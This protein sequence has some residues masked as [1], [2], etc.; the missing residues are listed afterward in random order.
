MG[1]ASRLHP[2]TCAVYPSA[3]PKVRG[4]LILECASDRRS[5]WARGLRRPLRPI[6][7]AALL[8]GESTM[9][10]DNL[11]AFPFHDRRIKSLLF[12]PVSIYADTSH[13]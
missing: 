8:C 4:Q 10:P 13:L 7:M 1:G 11:S 3:K 9:Q 5:G 6:E 2:E 12:D